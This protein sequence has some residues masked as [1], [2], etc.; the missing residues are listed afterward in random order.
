MLFI[1]CAATVA[2]IRQETASWRWALFSVALL[3]A[4]SL[5]AGT[6]IYQVASLF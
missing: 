6:A 2:V 3:T 1:P 4:A 5:L